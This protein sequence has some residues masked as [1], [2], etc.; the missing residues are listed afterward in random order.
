MLR[1]TVEGEDGRYLWAFI[2]V[3]WFDAR[4]N[5]LPGASAS[6]YH[7]HIRVNE[8]KLSGAGSTTSL[9][10]TLTKNFAVAAPA[11]AASFWL[12]LYVKT[13]RPAGQS[14]Q[15]RYGFAKRE[16][17]ALGPTG[18]TIHLRA[19]LRCGQIG[20]DGRPGRTG[21]AVGKI[22]QG[23]VPV[24]PPTGAWVAAWNQ[25]PDSD[26]YIMGW[27]IGS[28][29]ADGA[30][31]IPNLA[32]GQRYSVWIF[33]PGHSNITRW[34]VWI[35]PCA[36]SR[37]D[38]EIGGSA[39]GAGSGVDP[40]QLIAGDYDG[41]GYDDVLT[42][43]RSSLSDRLIR[44]GPRG[45]PLDREAVVINGNYEAGSG[46]LDGDGRDDILFHG[47]DGTYVWYGEANGFE[48]RRQRVLGRYEPLVD[49]FDGDERADILWYAP[50][51]RSDYLWLSRGSRGDKVSSRLQIHG[52]YE[53]V[54]GDFNGDERADILWYAPGAR[55][56]HLWLSQAAG[57]FRSTPTRVNGEYRPMTGDFDGNGLDDIL[58]YAPGP[59]PD[60]L[61]SHRL[62]GVASTPLSASGHY[63]A[64]TGDFDGD[65]IAD[66]AWRNVDPTVHDYIWFGRR[67]VGFSSQRSEL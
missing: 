37:V 56:D 45:T 6:G 50:G 65:G 62:Q 46:D 22:T 25:G 15:Q 44:G 2:G 14:D 39:P 13:D 63:H 33:R 9:R 7:C 30:L 1:G 10:G 19:P 27:N 52:S 59:R 40:H 43:G 26:S 17:A 49:D 34:N 21:E 47:D 28:W 24:P 54:V 42:Y 18:R 48:S 31:R 32:S 20:D 66:I 41:D 5:K 60:Y 12:E 57:G 23:G 35:N 67:V 8:N 29:D 53:P 38:V 51:G 64:A 58:W 36:T 61:W 3:E 16:K 4:G 11:Q 55:S